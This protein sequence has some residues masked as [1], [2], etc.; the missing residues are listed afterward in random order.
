MVLYKDHS[1]HGLG[2]LGY[3]WSQHVFFSYIVT[4]EKVTKGS[5]SYL[6]LLAKAYCR[7]GHASIPDFGVLCGENDV[8]GAPA[9]LPLRRLG[10]PLDRLFWVCVCILFFLNFPWV[11]LHFPWVFHFLRV[12]LH[13]PCVFLHF[14]C[15]FLHFAWVFLHFPWQ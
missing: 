9:P 6:S 11:F 8:R 3:T 7:E 4:S 2:R 5:V 13:F 14:P 1:S 12:F 10:S 15:V